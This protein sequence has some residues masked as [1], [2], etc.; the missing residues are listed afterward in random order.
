MTN[1][2]PFAK[3]E[4]EG[5]PTPITCLDRLKMEL[6]HKPYC[7]DDELCIFLEENG[8]TYSWNYDKDAM[9]RQL[10][11]T[12]ISILEM[13]SNNVDFYMKIELNF[14]TQSQALD[15]IIKRIAHL[16]RRI[17]LITQ[18][19]SEKGSDFTFMYYTHKK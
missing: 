15:N 4:G 17:D 18:A 16:H 13:L 10:L 14:Q 1:Y 8:L 19:E 2:P 3:P 9:E 6:G 11:Y 12:V 5:F 7:E